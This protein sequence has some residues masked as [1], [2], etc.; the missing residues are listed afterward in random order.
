VVALLNIHLLL[1]SSACKESKARLTFQEKIIQNMIYLQDSK[2]TVQDSQQVAKVF[3]HLLLLEDTIDQQKEHFYVMHLDTQS[4]INMVEL[5][6]V[7][8]LSSSLVHPRETFRR[9]VIQGSASIIAADEE[10]FHRQAE[11]CHNGLNVASSMALQQYPTV[12][13]CIDFQARGSVVMGRT[14]GHPSLATL[15]RPIKL[16]QHEVNG[17]S[18]G[19]PPF[20]SR[21]GGGTSRRVYPMGNL[22][23][24]GGR[25]TGV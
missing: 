1:K 9:A 15:A 19:T 14:A 10:I 2:I 21:A 13:T 4:R 18:H 16:A 8:T 6:S 12:V 22:R 24:V 11:T 5:V 23:L 17:V 20:R 25:Q 3:Y 7:G